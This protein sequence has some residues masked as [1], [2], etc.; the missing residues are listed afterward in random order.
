MNWLNLLIFFAIILA[1]SIAPVFIG[2]FSV[3]LLTEI[4][5]WGLFALAFDIIYGYTGMLSLGQ[6]V[7]FGL[8]AYGAVLSLIHLNLGLASSIFIGISLA[9]VFGLLIGVFVVRVGEPGFIVVTIISSLVFYLL[10]LDLTSITGGD[11]GLTVTVPHVFGNSFAHPRVNY[12]FVLGAVLIC[13]FLTYLLTRSKWGR[14]FKLIRENPD[15]AEAV[16]YDIYKF[17]LYSFIISALL[18]GFAGALYGLTSRFASADLFHWT[19][20]AEVV[21]WTLFGGAGTLVGPILGT[22]ILLAT[23]EIISSLLVNLY[24]ILL[25]VLIILVVNF[26]PS[27]LVGSFVKLLRK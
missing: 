27:G 26:F 7:F 15:R 20:S 8:G 22:G 9:G 1:L 13:F 5:I 3:L 11:D 14:T 24:P 2:P 6:S 19:V 23:Q 25:G 12:Y 17:R 18:S 16:G 21:I 10:C 4:L